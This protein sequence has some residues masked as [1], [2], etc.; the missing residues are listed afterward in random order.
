DVHAPLEIAFRGRGDE[1][2]DVALGGDLLGAILP[3]DDVAEPLALVVEDRARDQADRAAAELER[4]RV[5]LGEARK[6]L[7]HSLEV[8]MED[9][10]GSADDA[11]G[12]EVLYLAA[13]RVLVLEE[14]APRGRVDVDDA[15]VGVGDHHGAADGLERVTDAPVLGGLAPL[16]LEPLGE[17]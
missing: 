2:L 1:V 15:E 16:G 12:A 7:A 9:L 8:A 14:Q 3:F 10:E 17:P 6:N 13:E 11:F 4:R 5:A